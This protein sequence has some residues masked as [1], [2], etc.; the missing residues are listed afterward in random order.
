MKIK[1]LNGGGGL[2]NFG[3]PPVSF[4]ILYFI[5]FIMLEKRIT[6]HKWDGM[7]WNKWNPSNLARCHLRNH[8]QKLLSKVTRLTT[9][10]VTFGVATI[11][12][13]KKKK[14]AFHP[15]NF[16]YLF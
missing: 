13:K 15:L 8:T 2:R 3:T 6:L 11:I 7:G 12:T 9:T 10:F 4:Y 16:I 1:K 14:I 5:F